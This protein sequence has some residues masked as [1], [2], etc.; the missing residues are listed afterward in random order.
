MSPLQ[1]PQGTEDAAEALLAAE[2]VSAK[3]N[4]KK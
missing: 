4:I 1:H 3:P 2:M